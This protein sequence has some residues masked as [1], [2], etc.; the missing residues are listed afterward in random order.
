MQACMRGVPVRRV[1]GSGPCRGPEVRRRVERTTVSFVP[2]PRRSPSG[3][4]GVRPVL[5]GRSVLDGSVWLTD[6]AQAPNPLPSK[7]VQ[8]QGSVRSEGCVRR[9]PRTSGGDTGQRGQDLAVSVGKQCQDFQVE[10]VDI[11]P[12][13]AVS[14]EVTAQSAGSLF[15]ISRRRQAPA[16]ALQ[17]VLGGLRPQAS[18]GPTHQ[19]SQLRC[20][21]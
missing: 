1:P 9:K 6:R 19:R 18:G 16:P 2:V 17:P 11:C 3:R 8:R 10:G 15:G 21:S 12:Q 13:V 5:V 20:P 7:G 4:R 14:V